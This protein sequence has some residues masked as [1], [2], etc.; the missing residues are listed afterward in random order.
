MKRI[1]SL[2][3][4]AFLTTT[5]FAS[6]TDS[7]SVIIENNEKND[8]FTLNAIATRTEYRREEI[9]DVCYREVF[10]HY[11]R[12]CDRFG[13]IAVNDVIGPHPAPGPHPRDP[14]DPPV[15]HK[16]PGSMRQPEPPTC[17]DEPVYRQVSY[18]CM[19]TISVPY[20]VDDHQSRAN[21]NVRLSAAPN[22][23][24]QSGNCGI[25]FILTG[26]NFVATN[27]CAEYLAMAKINRQDSGNK[28]NYSY[29]I[30]LYDAQK[31]FAPLAGGLNEMHVDGNTLIVKTG[32]LKNYSNFT[33]KLYVQRRKLFSSDIT[34][35][36]RVLSSSEFSY[37]PIDAH[38]GTVRIDLDKVA[39]GFKRG[40]KHVIKIDLSVAL[41]SGTMLVNRGIPALNQEASITIR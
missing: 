22:N 30:D 31:V 11:E 25:N 20:E 27:S 23:L 4:L 13:Y 39:A 40:K 21:V 6:T 26:D 12:V 35:I 37:T 7:R 38:T 14:R 15:E 1:F 9:R 3:L 8:S 18:S 10:D 33:L 19:R 29:S 28:K 41:P 16:D 2:L 24:P 36:D 34:L 32:D 5:T 17:Y